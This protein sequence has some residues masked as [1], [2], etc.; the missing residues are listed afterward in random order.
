MLKDLKTYTNYSQMYNRRHLLKA[1]YVWMPNFGVF[2]KN[3]R[4]LT[5]KVVLDF[6]CD[7]DSEVYKQYRDQKNGRGSYWGFDR[8]VL[9]TKWL[10]KRGI[11]LD[12]WKQNK[13][14]FDVI[15]ASQVYEHLDEK[16]RE[17][18]LIKSLESLKP[19]GKLYLDFPYV[20]NLGLMEFFQ[21]RTHK[22]VS[23]ID[24]AMFL[25]QIGF[26]VTLYAGGYSMPYAS[27]FSYKNIA[28]I[29]ANILLGY[30][31]FFV[32]FIIAEK[33]K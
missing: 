26:R 30:K 25:K 2:I 28:R 29:I 12:F 15:N 22:P 21:D 8:S 33:L 32:T 23:F 17:A 11:Y 19:G 18:F 31:P 4:S 14:S 10:K 16:Q 7:I 6:G 3:H 1:N 27:V 13:I 24:E 9:A 5:N 20:M